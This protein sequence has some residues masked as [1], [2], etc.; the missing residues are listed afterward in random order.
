[1]NY[2]FGIKNDLFR[3]DITV[4]KFKNSSE[5]SNCKLFSARPL[6]DKWLIK[7]LNCE[8]NK[9]FFFIKNDQVENDNIFFLANENELSTF[10]V[11]NFKNLEDINNFTDTKPSAFRSNLKIYIKDEGFSSY[12]SEYPF[13]MTKKNGNILSP[14]HSLLNKDADKNFIFFKNIF[15]KPNHDESKLFLIDI[16]KKKILS[17]F[18]IKNNFSNKI[19][20]KK[21]L[22]NENIFLFTEKALGIP[23]FVSVKEKHI[24]FEHTHPHHHYIISD[25]QFDIIN[26]LKKEIKKLADGLY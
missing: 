8:Q 25:N 10:E 11:N 7:K 21:D 23:L 26:N 12:Q 1:M 24:S 18:I 17:I 3:C 15:Y 4:P 9:N 14:I 6:K 5:I 20:I 2:F 13:S 22:I 19:E 16:K